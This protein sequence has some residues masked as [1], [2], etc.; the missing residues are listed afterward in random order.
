MRGSFFKFC[1]PAALAGSL[2]SICGAAR[3]G[4]RATSAG[5]ISGRT[6]AAPAAGRPL[7]ASLAPGTGKAPASWC[8]EQGPCSRPAACASPRAPA[9]C[10]SSRSTHPTDCS[11]LP[12]HRGAAASAH[13]HRA[14]ARRC[15]L[16]TFVAHAHARAGDALNH[17]HVPYVILIQCIDALAERDEGV[18]AGPAPHHAEVQAQR[19]RVIGR[20]MRVISAITGSRPANYAARRPAGASPRAAA[21]AP[22]IAGSLPRAAAFELSRGLGRVLWGTDALVWSGR[23][24]A[25]QSHAAAPAHRISNVIH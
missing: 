17:C 18:A 23:D 9:G 2:T 13:Y 11:I 10:C 24:P 25:T 5:A 20:G 16:R 3:R 7:D 21:R 8:C 12:F 22:C 19:A 6:L 1:V 14:A 4:R 15:Q